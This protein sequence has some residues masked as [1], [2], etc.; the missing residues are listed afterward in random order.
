MSLSIQKPAQ[1]HIL[2]VNLED[3][4]QVGPLSSVIP[5]RYWPHFETR[6]EQNTLAVLD[7]LDQHGIK[8]TF[9]AV[10]WIAD[11]LGEFLAEITRRGHEV[12]SKG[13]LHRSLDQMSPDE[14]R[15]DVVRSRKAL[16]RAC[17]QA[18]QGYRIAR[19]WFSEADVWALD[20]LAEEGFSYDSSFRPL[21]RRFAHDRRERTIHKRQAGQG[22][23]W[24]LPLSSWYFCGLCLPI[25]GGNYVRQLPGALMRWRMDRWAETAEAPLIFYFHTWELDPAQPRVESVPWLSRVR[26]YRNLEAMWDR[27]EYCLA[28]YDFTSIADYL[29]LEARAADAPAEASSQAVVP[30]AS[31]G[32]RQPLTVVVPCYNESLVLP[33]SARTLDSFARDHRDRYDTFFV[34]VDDSSTDETWAL[35]QEL[36]GD[37]DDCLL[38]QHNRNR[39]IAAGTL[40]GINHARS[41][42]VCV[43]DCDCSYEIQQL[44]KMIALM[45]EDVD[46]VTASPYH[47]DGS[48]VNVPGWRLFLSRGL[49]MLYRLVFNQKLATYTACFRVYRRSAVADIEIQNEGFVGIA[50][51]LAELDSRGSK[52]V[53]APAVLEARLFGRSKM[54]VVMAIWAHLQL[55]SR[56]VVHKRLAPRLEKLESPNEFY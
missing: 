33:Y 49:S 53:E 38:V 52:I 50:E 47:K 56:L 26:Q 19:G 41:E 3:Y 55:L 54:K 8:A 46:C 9:F 28:R 1:R 30:A 31:R 5:Q 27:V 39:G 45:D 42:L 24:E 40:T 36:F 25:S 4:F 7:L 23:I 2:T 13:Y 29:G 34:F 43:I 44:N 11:Q 32:K 37:R 12:A 20:I 14:F 17:G 18:V 48:V 22:T 21:G 15:E 10:G 51:I 6:V 16:E 35:L